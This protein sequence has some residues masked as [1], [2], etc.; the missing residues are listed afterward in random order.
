MEMCNTFV[1]LKFLFILNYVFPTLTAKSAS[2]MT[3]FAKLCLCWFVL[4]H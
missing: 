1:L 2:A 3:M 4:I